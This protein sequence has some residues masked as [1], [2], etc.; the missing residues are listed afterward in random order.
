M[1]IIF[2]LNFWFLKNKYLDVVGKEEGLLFI[3]DV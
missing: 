1:S 2:L 3:D